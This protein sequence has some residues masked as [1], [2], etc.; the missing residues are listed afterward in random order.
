MC[1]IYCKITFSEWWL[2]I[3]FPSSIIGFIFFSK[4]V[5]NSFDDI[6]GNNEIGLYE[7]V[8]W[9]ILSGGYQCYFCNFP[10]FGYVLQLKCSIIR[11]VSFNIPFCGSCFKTSPLIKSNPETF[12]GFISSFTSENISFYHQLFLIKV[13]SSS[14]GWNVLSRWSAY[15]LLF[16]RYFLP[17]LREYV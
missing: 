9:G 8:Y 10:H 7:K 14:F 5:S 16:G 12:F 17:N 1:L 15:L 2:G 13:N 3:R 6:T 11:L 4:T